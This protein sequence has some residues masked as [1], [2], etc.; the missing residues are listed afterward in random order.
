MNA[1]RTGNSCFPTMSEASVQVFLG[2]FLGTMKAEYIVWEVGP[3]EQRDRKDLESQYPLW[4]T[5]NFSSDFSIKR[6]HCLINWYHTFSTWV[7]G[8]HAIPKLW[9]WIPKSNSKLYKKYDHKTPRRNESQH[10]RHMLMIFCVSKDPFS[11]T[12]QVGSRASTCVFWE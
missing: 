8:R 12:I 1:H 9:H 11:Q 10:R 5:P 3:E 4:T 7:I 6:F 2:L